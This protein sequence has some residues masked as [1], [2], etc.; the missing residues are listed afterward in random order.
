MPIAT[1]RIPASWNLSKLFL[2]TRN[3]ELQDGHQY[4]R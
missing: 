3:S 4:P 1:G 2:N